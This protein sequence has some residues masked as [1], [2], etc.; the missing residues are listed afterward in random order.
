MLDWAII[1]FVFSLNWIF[2]ADSHAVVSLLFML[3]F[4][5]FPVDVLFLFFFLFCHALFNLVSLKCMGLGKN[6]SP[7]LLGGIE[8]PSWRASSRHIS[9][10]L[11][12][13]VLTQGRG[14]VGM[15]WCHGN[16][17]SGDKDKEAPMKETE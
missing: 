4:F 13:C 3:L 7:R 8:V 14:R 10:D 12:I 11:C 9:S 2:I 16:G 5:A 1:K 15:R 17:E 6:R